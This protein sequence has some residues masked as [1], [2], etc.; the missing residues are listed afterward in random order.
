[1]PINSNGAFPLS[2]AEDLW[3]LDVARP[4]CSAIFLSHW[5]SSCEYIFKKKVLYLCGDL[6][7]HQRRVRFSDFVLGVDQLLSEGLS[8]LF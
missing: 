8:G 3:L 4:C 6:N 2:S 5:C 7:T 1:M